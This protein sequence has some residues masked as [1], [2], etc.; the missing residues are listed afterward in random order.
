MGFCDIVSDD[1]SRVGGKI[2]QISHQFGIHRR[3]D[4]GEKWAVWSP[5]DGTRARCGGVGTIS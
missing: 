1:G 5:E 2:G 4:G 3:A